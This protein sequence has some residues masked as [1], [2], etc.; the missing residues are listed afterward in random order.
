LQHLFIYGSLRPGYP[1]EHVMTKIGGDWRAATIK[2]T[3]HSEGWGYVNHGLRGLVVDE[4]GE[5]IP[6]FV[7][8]STNLKDH[9]QT[10][11]EFEGGDYERVMARALYADGGGQDVFVYALK[12]G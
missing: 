2:G 4:A 12:R 6:G 7:F 9:W 8:S 3:W 1:N 10:L 5:D 11:D